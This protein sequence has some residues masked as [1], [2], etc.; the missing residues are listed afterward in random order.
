VN[1][2]SNLTCPPGHYVSKVVGGKEVGGY[3]SI[4]NLNSIECTN[5]MDPSAPRAV[6]SKLIGKPGAAQ[7]FDCGPA[8]LTGMMLASATVV[9][10][11]QAV[12]GT[13]LG[14]AGNADAFVKGYP[15]RTSPSIGGPKPPLLRNGAPEV[16]ESRETRLSSRPSREG[17]PTTATTQTP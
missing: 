17:R 14:M 1:G 5:Y 2:V 13:D 11:I 8:G 7:S 6:I 9:D 12:C 16:V 3:S 10:S 15:W 4:T